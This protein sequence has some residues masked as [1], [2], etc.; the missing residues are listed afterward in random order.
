MNEA[1]TCREMVRP[2]LEAAGWNQGQHTYATNGREILEFDYLTGQERLR[3]DF[4]TPDELWQRFLA[5]STLDE[6]AAR[7]FLTPS[8]RHAGRSLRYYQEI[9]INRALLA[10]LGGQR[11]A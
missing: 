9:A 2:K 5:G 8:Y 4:P 7:D 10:I 3:E 11:K 1:D 6:V